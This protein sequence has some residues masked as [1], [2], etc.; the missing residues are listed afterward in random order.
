MGIITTNGFI[1]RENA[2]FYNLTVTATDK[3]LPA[4]FANIHVGVRIL[5]END[6]P[7]IFNHKNYT[8]LIEEDAAIGSVLKQVCV[9]FE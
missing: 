6:N 9:M 3:G 8:V 2:S 5:D 4:L 7:P 1:D